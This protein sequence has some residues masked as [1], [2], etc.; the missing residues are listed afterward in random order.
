ME[1][2]FADALLGTCTTHYFCG[3]LED[4]VESTVIKF[5]EKVL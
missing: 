5:V 4:D 1:S 2:S 3:V